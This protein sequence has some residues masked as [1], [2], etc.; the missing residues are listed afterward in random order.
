ME[1]ILL[2]VHDP[3]DVQ[4]FHSQLLQ[5][6]V[7]GDLCFDK[8][9]LW[10]RLIVG[11]IQS[12]YYSRQVV[13]GCCGDASSQLQLL[14]LAQLAGLP[15]CQGSSS[16]CSETQAVY[17]RGGDFQD[18]LEWLRKQCFQPLDSR[19]SVLESVIAGSFAA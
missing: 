11:S 9:R 4:A 5:S 16:T 6:V 15:T 19:L 2:F 1:K 13:R 14:Q 17:P 8:T 12:E 3:T 10:I 18:G 7:A